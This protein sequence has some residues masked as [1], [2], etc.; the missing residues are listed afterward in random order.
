MRKRRH[1]PRVMLM[2][3]TS[4]AFGRGVIEGVA[5]YALENGPCSILFECR[6]FDS[7]APAWL[8]DWEGDGIISR[9]ADMRMAKALWATKLPMVELLGPM[10]VGTPQVMADFLAGGR[11]VVEHFLNCGLQ[12]FGYFTCDEAW[13][14]RNHR[15]AF[16][17][18]LGE[19]GRTCCCYRAPKSRRVVPAWH[20]RDRS[21]V[22]KWLR[23]LPRPIGIYTATDE[24]AV[25]L[26]DI[27][28]ELKIAVPE[29]MAI[30]GSSNDTL[31]C[32]TVRPTLSSL[33]INAWQVGYEAAR[34]LDRKMAGRSSSS[35]VVRIAPSHVAVRQSTDLMVIDDDDMV[36]A[37]E[38]IHAQGCTEIDVDRVAH[39]VGLSRRVLENRFRQHLGRAPKAEITRVRIERAKALLTRTDQTIESIT[40]KCGFASP[41][42][43]TRAFRREVGTTPHAYRKTQ[44]IA[45]APGA[46]PA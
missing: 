25:R 16:L 17:R 37:L 40:H 24:H 26:L 3:E 5:R 45:H 36:R 22:A 29:E 42:Y 20:E 9:T 6:A 14:P 35:D 43:F 38:F 11:M 46:P 41:T 19:R 12:K 31:I 8:K 44:R 21:H 39:E 15:D 34:L 28:R 10:G 33:D 30:L 23:T 13:W 18:A 7:P 32:E 1:I 4:R 27:C 2:V